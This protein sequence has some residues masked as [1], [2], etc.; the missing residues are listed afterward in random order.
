MH[1]GDIGQSN[2]LQIARRL[3]LAEHIVSRASR[4]LEQ[5]RGQHLP[6]LEVV[7]KLRKDAEDA[8]Q[9]ALAAQ[10]EAERNREALNQRLTDLQRQAENDARLAEAR[11]RLQPGDRVVV[12]RFGY[13]RPGRVVKL[14]LRKKTAVVAIGQMQ[15][16]VA[17]DELIPQMIR[18]PEVPSTT[19]K[20]KP[21]GPKAG[22]RLED[23]ADEPT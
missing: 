11:A 6:E 7:Q 5:S 16:D 21:G 10:A 8:R 3:N 22:L 12:P 17:I 18:D 19:A 23:F 9:A 15:W 4:H 14:D 13:D 2:A 1:I 20:V